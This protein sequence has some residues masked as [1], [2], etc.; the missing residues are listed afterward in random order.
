MRLSLMSV[1]RGAITVNLVDYPLHW[2]LGHHVNYVYQRVR[3]Q[4]TNSL[5]GA[6]GQLIEFAA[7]VIQEREYRQPA[8]WTAAGVSR[9]WPAGPKR[10]A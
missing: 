7:L 4:G 2:R 9:R 6:L 8:I 1:E 5:G 3:L 10:S